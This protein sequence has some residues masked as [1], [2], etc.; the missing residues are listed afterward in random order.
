M[1]EATWVPCPAVS[2]LSGSSVKFRSAT[3]LPTRS[4]CSSSTPVS[5]T[6][7]VTPLPVSPACHAAGA[8]ICLVLRS[9]ARSRLPS[10]HTFPTAPSRS[11][12]HAPP[13]LSTV[14]ATAP[15]ASSRVPTDSAPTSARAPAA[16]RTITGT[17]GR[18]ASS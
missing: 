15:T 17:V 2:V 6:A 18:R 14:P 16:V 9:S 8:P 3:W 4:G 10:S 13:F 11:A 1:I 5:S 7:T 12:S